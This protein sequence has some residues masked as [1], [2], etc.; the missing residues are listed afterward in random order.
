[1]NWLLLI[2]VSLFCVLV[3]FLINL[4]DVFCILVFMFLIG[5]LLVVWISFGIC[6]SEFWLNFGKLVFM[7]VGLVYVCDVD[8]MVKFF[9]YL[10]LILLFCSF[11]YVLFDVMNMI[12]LLVMFVSLLLF[13]VIWMFFVELIC[14]LLFWFCSVIFFWLVI[15]DMF[16]LCVNIVMLCLVCRLICCLFVYCRW[17]CVMILMLLFVW[18]VMVFG[19]VMLMLVGVVM[20]IVVIDV[21]D[22]LLL[23]DVL[24]FG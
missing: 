20:L 7:F 1:M 24:L 6:F 17:F 16:L 5:C 8:L 13:V 15:V 19:V 4:F 3:F 21:F 23:L 11:R 22:D 12:C 14:V 18:V 2:G 9:G 10:S